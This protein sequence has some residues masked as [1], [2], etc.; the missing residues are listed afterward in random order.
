MSDTPPANPP[1]DPAQ[2]RKKL[3]DA[4]KREKDKDAQIRG[5]TVTNTLHEAQL[6]HLNE[7]QRKALLGVLPTDG[8]VTT[9][10]LKTTATSLGFPSAPVPPA[11]PST[12]QAPPVMDGDQN[13]PD[14][15]QPGQT[16]QPTLDPGTNF[17]T[18]APNSPHPDPRVDA[19]ITGLTQQEHAHIMSL[20]GGQ[21]G[22]NFEEKLTQAKTKEEALAVIRQQG[23]NV[24]ILLDSDLV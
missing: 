1:D 5:L 4:L 16:L 19:S 23:G 17:V 10:V 7:V 8:E 22:G 11:P 9:E 12:G 13:Q 6:G 3:D 24:G 14:P 18:P 21:N 20:R 2:L 15:N